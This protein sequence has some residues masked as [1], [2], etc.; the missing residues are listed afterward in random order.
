MFSTARNSRTSAERP[1]AAACSRV[2]TGSSITT[3]FVGGSCGS[4]SSSGCHAATT[5]RP[6]PSMVSSPSTTTTRAS[7]MKGAVIA[8]WMSSSTRSPRGGSSVVFVSSIPSTSSEARSRVYA[9]RIRKSSG[10]V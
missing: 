5:L 3:W 1:R 8:C 9:S 4:T 10:P 7:A 2:G 6:V